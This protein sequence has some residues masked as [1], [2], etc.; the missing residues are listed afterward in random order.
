MKKD[1][2]EA[3]IRLKLVKAP[4][5]AIKAQERLKFPPVEF[6]GLKADIIHGMDYVIPPTL[7]K[8]IVLTI[9]DLAFM[10]FPEFN[11]SWFIEKYRHMVA[12]NSVLA[13]RILASSQSTTDDILKYF[14]A[15]NDKVR[16]VHLAAGS[17]FRK[18]AF[19]EID[20]SVPRCFNISTPFLFSVGTIEPRKDFVTLIK[21]YELARD[22]DPGFRHKLAIA[23]RTGWKSEKTYE[24]RESSPYK[25]DIIFT[26]RLTDRELIQLYN[27]SDI[28][29]YTSLFEGFGFPP[30]EAMGCGLPVICSDSSSIKEVV[31]DAGILIQPG[32]AKCFSEN[33]LKVCGD[34]KIKGDLSQKS[35]KRSKDF[36]WQKTAEKTLSVYREAAGSS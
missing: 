10:R 12:R 26:G 29:V 32:D 25:D 28:F 1:F 13:K 34:N 6:F 16:T 8:N 24:S 15:G 35:L 33:I 22:M 7:N 20:C 9:H 17:E 30:L 11:F 19:N 2:P 21:A 4:V 27:Q 23:G 14:Q 5:S 18:L 31:G 36:T 3:D